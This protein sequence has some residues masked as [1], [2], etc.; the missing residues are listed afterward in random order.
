M[1]IWVAGHRGLVGSAV[2][3]RIESS[4]GFTWVG[5][6]RSELD[7]RDPD[8]TKR[9]L[10]QEKPDAVVVA[11]ARVGGI[12]ANKNAPLEF[13][14]DNL[15]IQNSIL[16]ACIE[17]GIENL[18]FLSSSC[19]Y[20]KYSAQ[21][22]KEGY[23]LSGELEETNKSY[24]L[25]K[26]AGHRI[27][28]IAKEA[29]KQWVTAY[30]TNVYGANDN[31]DESSSHVLAAFISKFSRSVRD[32]VESL[33]LL[34]DG[35]P[36]REFIHSD[37]LAEAI[38]TLVCQSNLK[39]DSYNVGT[40]EEVSIKALASLVSRMTGYTGGVTWDPTMPN[41]TPRKL[42]DSSRIR[43]LGWLPNLSLEDGVALEIQRFTQ[44]QQH[45]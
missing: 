13:L 19:V 4:P 20:P 12:L 29:G 1:K 7:L 15:E 25:A 30:P 23:L 27:V 37:D 34:G 45:D 10:K 18:V 8:L 5:R 39:Y 2:V 33:T 14:I 35:T 38:L 9:F 17:F 6:S 44:G 42:L 40:G 32:G 11:A 31:Y 22:I 3:R 26:I 36:L 24:A 16:T 43:E 41:G 21:P 28:E